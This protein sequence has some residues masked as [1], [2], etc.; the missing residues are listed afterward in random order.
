[1][2]HSPQL[3]S[4]MSKEKKM[5]RGLRKKTSGPVT[6]MCFSFPLRSCDVCLNDFN[7]FKGFSDSP[8]KGR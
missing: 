6:R 8:R 1:M 3:H 2:F 5:R 4:W 7:H